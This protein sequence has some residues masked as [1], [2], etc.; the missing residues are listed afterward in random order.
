MGI[1]SIAQFAL[2]GLPVGLVL[3][4]LIWVT[5]GNIIGGGILLGL[6]SVLISIEE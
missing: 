3:R 2:G 1:F 6:P 4:N 5:L